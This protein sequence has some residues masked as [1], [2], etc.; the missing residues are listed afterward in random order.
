[1]ELEKNTYFLG[2]FFLNVHVSAS[3]NLLEK[4]FL[5]NKSQW[6][7]HSV[8]K[9]FTRVVLKVTSPHLILLWSCFVEEIL[10]LKNFRVIIEGHEF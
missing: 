7:S 2:Q 4:L 9:D 3:K 5:L 1:M 8:V 10:I 6:P